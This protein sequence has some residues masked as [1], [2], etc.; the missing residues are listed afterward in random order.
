VI[1]AATAQTAA[2]D[3]AAAVDS[4]PARRAALLAASAALVA[5]TL[6]AFDPTACQIAVARLALPLGSIAWPQRTHLELRRRV[7]Q[8]ARGQ[9]FEVEVIDAQRVPLPA[10]VQIHYRTKRP[11]GSTTVESERLRRQGPA[12]LARRETV[13]HPFA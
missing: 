6:V 8:V 3:F 10:D 12:M 1:E 5:V 7:V 2:I 11:D 13:T 4:R 9:A